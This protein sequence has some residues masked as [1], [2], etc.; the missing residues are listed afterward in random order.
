MSFGASATELGLASYYG[1][2]GLT[3]AHRSLPMGSR[4]KVLNLDNGRSV[5]LSIMDRGPFIRGRVIDVSTTA[6]EAL[7]FRDAG[8]AHV[9]ID[10]D[11][12]ETREPGPR[13]ELQ[14][15]SLEASSY[16]ICRYVAER[17]HQQSDWLSAEA[18]AMRN[19]TGCE[20]SGSQ[21]FGLVERSEDLASFAA[22][23]R[24]SLTGAE[25]A[26]NIP[27]SAIA[28]AEAASIPVSAIA[29]AEAASIPVGALPPVPESEAPPVRPTT[30]CGAASSCEKEKQPSASNFVVLP[31]PRLRQIFDWIHPQTGGMSALAAGVDS[32]ETAPRELEPKGSRSERPGLR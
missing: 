6:A 22:R 23:S 18:T 14:L 4:V 2:A 5:I 16:E 3:A 15:A 20:N 30:G 9:K 25:A 17:L 27:V 7:G 26:I 8:L 21:R 28:V 32:R 12:P 31:F 19:D 29:E 1:A 24:A 13:A 11:S 10:A